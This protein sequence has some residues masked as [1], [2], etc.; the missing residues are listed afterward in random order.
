LKQ[1]HIVIKRFLTKIDI[2]LRQPR[3][4]DSKL[5]PDCEDSDMI[6][7]YS[8]CNEESSISAHYKDSLVKLKKEILT[9]KVKLT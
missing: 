6:S 4:F 5:G 9:L 2:D 7:A 3:F 1:A 8:N